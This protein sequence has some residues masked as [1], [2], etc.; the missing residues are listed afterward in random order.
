MAV[1]V[2]GCGG[3]AESADSRGTSGDFDHGGQ[4]PGLGGAGGAGGI[5]GGFGGFQDGGAFD[6]DDLARLPPEEE[7]RAD[8]EL[9]QASERYVYATNPAAGTVSIIEA[10]T[11]AITTLQ[12]GD[13]PTYLR[14]LPG[15]D[16]AIVLNVGS[17]DATLIRVKDG[18]PAT[19]TLDVV[20][21]A[22]A[23]ALAPDGK[24]AVVYFDSRLSEGAPSGSF[25]ELSVI[26]LE[27]GADTVV[28]M[29]VA[30][31]P[32]DVFFDSAGERAF[33][34]TRD[35]ISVLDFDVV[36]REGSGIARL[37]LL[38]SDVG[39]DGLDVSVTPDGRFALAAAPDSGLLRLVDLDS[40]LIRWL[41][42]ADVYGTGTADEDGGVP[43]P[44]LE[45]TDLDLAP[46]GGYAL[47]ALRTQSAMLRI[48]VPGAFDDPN[49]VQI[50]EVPNEVIGS[51]SIVPG[52]THAL[53][54][55]TA[56]PIE[57]M[58][59]MPLG[60][61]PTPRTVALRK[62][63]RA[64]AASPDGQ[65]ALILHSKAEGSPNEPG[66]AL[67]TTIDRSHGY[68]LLR[69]ATGDV[70][71]QITPV[72]TGAYALTR[73]GGFLVLLLRDDA[74]ALRQVQ[75]VARKSFLVESFSLG[76][77]PISVGAVPMTNR[78][79]VGQEHPDG[80]VTFI[81]YSSGEVQTVT[82]FE[83]NSRIRD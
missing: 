52:E 61:A 45:V 26:T 32:G 15:T 68:S 46:S 16:D 41:D 9:P 6:E 54:Y 69:V 12:T 56:V 17:D 33:V 53:L 81:D 67:D 37:V 25:Q 5:G 71:L 22:N 76:S 62:A 79:F 75:Q 8:F 57:R 18:K 11:L 47:A 10:E 70:K 34:V 59:I 21:G 83:L 36:D 24:H 13:R 49:L 39:Q 3:M 66:L 42:L 77:P 19:V 14:T 50:F 1:L 7:V 27:P 72:Q 48:P 74:T 29:S 63:I 64:V 2:A 31:Q 51:V 55:T 43:A 82:G 23:I 65:T 30:F 4:G 80:R 58:T 28:N 38:G 78:L 60:E 73:D 20:G 35:G 44:V 40:G